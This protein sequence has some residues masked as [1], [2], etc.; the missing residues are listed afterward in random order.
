[1]RVAPEWFYQDPDDGD[2]LP[3]SDSPSEPADE[4]D[5]GGGSGCQR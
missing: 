2:T 4:P 1:M 5:C 3:D